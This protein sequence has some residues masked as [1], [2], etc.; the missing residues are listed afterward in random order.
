M[1]AAAIAMGAQDREPKMRNPLDIPILLSGNFGELRTNHFHSG[2]DL[3][4]MAV[5]GKAVRAVDDGYVARI[6][7]SPWGFGNALYLVHPSGLKTVYGH[8]QRFSD[9]IA[10]YVKDLQ[11][12]QEDFSVDISLAADVFPVSKGD[13]I[14]LSGNSGSSGGP[15]LHFEVRDSETDAVVDPLRYYKGMISDT[16]PPRIDAF[17]VYPLE[18]KGA[19]N[20]GSSPL[21]LK[22]GRSKEGTQTISGTANVWGEIGIALKAY[23]YMDGTTNIYGV[24]QIIMGV[25]GKIVFN[26]KLDSFS[27]WPDTRYINS[28]IDPLQWRNNRAFFMKSF[29]EP[30]NRLHSLNALNRGILLVNEERQYRITYIARDAYGNQSKQ[31]F[32]VNGK[33]QAIAPE[34]TAGSELFHWRGENRFGAKGVRL[35]IPDGNLYKSFRFRY[36]VGSDNPSALSA[37]HYLHETYV[38][39]HE[40][41]QL[42]IRLEKDSLVDKSKY[43]IVRLQGNRAVWIGGKYSNGW[44]EASIRELG[45]HTVMADQTPPESK[46]VNPKTWVSKQTIS[47]RI[48][49]NLSG[50]QTYR[51]EIDGKYA[52]FE[53]DGKRS[54]ATYQFDPSRLSRGKHKLA[55]ILTDACGNKSVYEDSFNW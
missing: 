10:A 22:I 20:G 12:E 51:G 54:L 36:A 46:P 2:I 42:S 11:Y 21:E 6:V 30:G 43:G 7:V 16:R 48:S 5:E 17:M 52:L 45:A 31:T 35:A 19:V 9:K 40:S 44:I 34:D 29:I 27:I 28:F 32:V 23:D 38:P 53:L 49:D 3:K 47:I 18:G 50:I 37:V 1:L 8:L 15:H 41:A 55:F 4:T 13:L 26:S 14:A 33:R 39:L 25:D 24:Q